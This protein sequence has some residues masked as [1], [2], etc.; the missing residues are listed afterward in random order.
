M[1]STLDIFESSGFLPVGTHTCTFPVYAAPIY[2]EEALHNRIADTCQ[3]IHNYPDGL[4]GC[5]CP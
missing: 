4:N 3:T 1:A 5:G 2:S